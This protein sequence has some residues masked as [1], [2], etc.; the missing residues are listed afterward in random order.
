LRQRWR[1]DQANTRPEFDF[2]WNNEFMPITKA[3]A[4][5]RILTFAQ[6]EPAI[7]RIFRAELQVMVLHNRSTDELDYERNPDLRAVVVGG[8]K[9]SRGLTVEG[10]LVSYYVRRANYFD[11]LLQ[12][13]RWFGYRED[14]VDLT[15]L[16]T[17]ADLIDRF[18]DLATA[19]EDLRR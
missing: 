3:I 18:R 5:D 19:E 2:R 13:G 4:P 12:M 10:F 7:S 15:R 9:L 1:Y 16:W 8:N 17:T 14:Y 11:T 6:V